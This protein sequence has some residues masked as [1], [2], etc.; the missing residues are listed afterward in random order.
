MNWRERIVV[1][2]AVLDG[3]PVVKGTRL[4]VELLLGWLAQRWTLDDLLAS[5]PRLSREDVLAALA[6]SAEALRCDPRRAGSVAARCAT[7]AQDSPW[8]ADHAPAATPA[9]RERIV[10]SPDTLSGRPRIAGSRIGVDFMLDLIGSGWSAARIVEEHP[11]LKTEDLEA[12]IAF[13]H[14]VVREHNAP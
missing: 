14:D 8:R 4:S 13:A 5:Y 6:F 12:A 2:P 1:D 11:T 7:L 10:A 3:K 9:W